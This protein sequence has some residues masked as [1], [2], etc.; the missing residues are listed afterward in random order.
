[1]KLPSK[2]EVENAIQFLLLIYAIVWGFIWSY[3]WLWAKLDIPMEWWSLVVCVVLGVLS[4]G[5]LLNWI[6]NK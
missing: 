3:I 2:K 1:M 4:A 5:G 6:A